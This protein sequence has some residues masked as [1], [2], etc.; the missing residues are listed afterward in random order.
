MSNIK[1][2]TIHDKIRELIPNLP[3]IVSPEALDKLCED[4]SVQKFLKWFIENVNSNN[5]LTDD[6]IEL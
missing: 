5:I 1:G 6:C 3:S 2:S 4:D